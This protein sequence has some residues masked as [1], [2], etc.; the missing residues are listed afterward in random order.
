LTVVL[1]KQKGSKMSKINVHYLY[2]S[3]IL[4]GVL[5]Q[6]ALAQPA[7]A[8]NSCQGELASLANEW[9]AISFSP[10][11]KPGQTIVAGKD[12][13]VTSGGQFNYMTGLI[14]QARAEC[15]RGDTASAMQDITIVRDR[16]DRSTHPSG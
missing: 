9:N 14:R 15:D 5:G 7:L 16:L 6:S 12:G 10:P 3:V 8:G 4:F 13:H 1:A 11:S 2:I